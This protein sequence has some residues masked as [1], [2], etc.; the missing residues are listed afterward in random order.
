M[1]LY[2]LS[3]AM[4]AIEAMI[5]EGAEGLEDTLEALDLSFQQKAEGCM[6]LR[7]SKLAEADAIKAEIDR[8]QARESKL[9]KDAE[10]FREYVERNML[11]SNMTEV[12][13]SLFKIKLGL[14]PPKVEVLNAS[15][16]PERYVRRTLTTAPDK[17]AIKEALK[18]G[19]NVPGARIVQDM[20][21]RV[22]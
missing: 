12:K 18:A 2:E 21:L 19:E 13:S 22:G 20:K 8:L 15:L 5:E 3:E 7:Q 6:K 1:K 17:T 10:W 4:Q 9:R 16:L 14:N 11:A